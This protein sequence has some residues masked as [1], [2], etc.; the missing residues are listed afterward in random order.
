MN[1][2]LFVR[3]AHE[4]FLYLEK[5][6]IR[7]RPIN[8][9]L[10]SYSDQAGMGALFH[11]PEARDDEGCGF[12]LSPYRGFALRLQVGMVSAPSG[13]NHYTLEERAFGAT[14]S[15]SELAGKLARYQFKPCQ[16]YEPVQA[17]LVHALKAVQQR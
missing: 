13:S 5:S 15:V 17:A 6:R 8:L 4:I 10:R 3:I 7:H 16:G 14:G 11:K 1:A 2:V 9:V 12:L